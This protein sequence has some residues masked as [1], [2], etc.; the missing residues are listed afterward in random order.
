MPYVLKKIIRGRTY[1]YLVKNVRVGGAWKKFTVYIGKG[2]LGESS[3]NKLKKKYFKTLD[4]KVVDYLKLT[5]PLFGL[6]PEKQINEL[7]KIRTA[8]RKANKQMS[9][10]VRKRWYEWFLAT[11]TYNSNAIE[12]STVNL[13][14][15][16][17]ILFEGLTPSGKTMREVREVENH[18]KAFDYLVGYKGELNKAFVCKLHRVMT[19]GILEP[20]ESGVFRGVQVFIRGSEIVPP[21]SEDVEKLFKELMLWYRGNKKR[22]H[23]AVVAAYIHTAFEGIHPFIDYN[24]RTG[25]LLLNSILMKNGFPPIAIAY[26]KRTKYYE[27]IQA[28]INGNLKPF[29]QLVYTY[30]RDTKF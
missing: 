9:A 26:R 13:L 27:A 14:E 6:L 29:V 18:R 7:E 19:S 22:Y 11:F 24:G 10:A 8:Y 25:R 30:L 28:A 5:D 1:F 17:A 23:P 2:H 20:A 16:S 4:Q 21:K 12:G 3:L 15:T